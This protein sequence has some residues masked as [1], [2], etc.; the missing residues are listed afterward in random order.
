MTANILGNRIQSANPPT[1]KKKKVKMTLRED[2]IAYEWYK[3]GVRDAALC[4]GTSIQ[5]LLKI[6]ECPKQNLGTVSRPV[7][8]RY[9]YR[10]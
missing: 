9:S 5:T 2:L 10:S 6:T 7:E 8:R 1:K 3:H 4:H